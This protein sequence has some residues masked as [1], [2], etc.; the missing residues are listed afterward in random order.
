[1]VKE[2]TGAQVMAMAEDVP[3]LQKMTPGGKPHIAYADLQQH[4][5]DRETAP[6]LVETR[7]AVRHI[8]ARKGM[9]IIPGDPD[10][11]SAGSFFKNRCSPKNNTRI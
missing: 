9:V 1:M 3:A 6:K 4:F 2:L 8:R 5:E 7:E 10:C 11:K